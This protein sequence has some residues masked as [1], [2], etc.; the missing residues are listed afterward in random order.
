MVPKVA[1]PNPS[2]GSASALGDKLGLELWGCLFPIEATKKKEQRLL[3][4]LGVSE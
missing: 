1:G 4:E 3:R 2:S